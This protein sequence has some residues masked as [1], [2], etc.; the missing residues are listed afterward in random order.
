MRKTIETS[1]D[2]SEPT[3]EDEIHLDDDLGDNLGDDLG[4]YLREI[5]SIPL[6]SAA[7]EQR[8]AHEIAQGNETAKQQFIEANLRLVV[9]IARKYTGLGLCLSDLIQEG[10]LGLMKA[11]ERFDPAKGTKFS[12]YATFWIRQAMSRALS[13]KGRT[14]RLPVHLG[15]KIRRLTQLRSTLAYELGHEPTVKELAER[16]DLQEG[17][18]FVLLTASFATLSLDAPRG[19]EG[20]TRLSDCLED[21]AEPLLDDFA[22][23]HALAIH[24]RAALSSL[25]ERER[26]A[27]ML[28]YGL[29]EE[30]GGYRRTLS[31]VG[32]LLGITRERVR[33][34]E[35]RGLERLRTCGASII[36]RSYLDYDLDLDR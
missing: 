16:M 3:R 32:V 20:E 22:Q 12:T 6:I 31:Q 24:L 11:V 1:I 15:E 18:V 19:E 13:D 35:A 29:D 33:Q 26:Q 5:G 30:A 23:Q 21:E 28:R 25:S 14:V 7:D 4:L 36:L 10:N 9:S 17:Q 2:P 27:L 34:L 8:L